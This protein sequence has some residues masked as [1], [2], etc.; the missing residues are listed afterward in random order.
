MLVIIPKSIFYKY[1]WY[2]E[3]LFAAVKTEDN[4]ILFSPNTFYLPIKSRRRNL[5]RKD[6]ISMMEKDIRDIIVIN[7]RM[8]MDK[9]RGTIRFIPK[10][11]RKFTLM[12]DQDTYELLGMLAH[13]FDMTASYLL[14]DAFLNLVRNLK[15]SREILE[16]VEEY[17]K[18]HEGSYIG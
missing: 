4:I 18:S 5:S 13:N 17:T 6:T 15:P 10:R 12:M 11:R 2:P 1:A 3:D 7:G 8:K 9:S 16:L 14:K